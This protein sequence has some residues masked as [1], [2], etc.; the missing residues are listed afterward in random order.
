[1]MFLQASAVVL[2][3][4][5]AI[6]MQVRVLLL[7]ILLHNAIYILHTANSELQR[8]YDFIINM[9]IHIVSSMK[10]TSLMCLYAKRAVGTNTCGK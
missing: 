8:F 9:H 3:I 6:T 5:C 10:Y 1:M 4:F 2:F 7:E